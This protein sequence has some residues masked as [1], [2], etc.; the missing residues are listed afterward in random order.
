MQSRKLWAVAIIIISACIAIAVSYSQFSAEAISNWDSLYISD[1]D[2]T[3]LSSSKYLQDAPLTTDIYFNDEKLLYDS[4]DNTFYYSLIDDDE[5]AYSPV[6]ELSDSS[7]TLTVY[8][9]SISPESIAEGVSIQLILMQGNIVSISNLICT[10]LPIMNVDIASDILEQGGYDD[11]YDILTDVPSSIYL[12]DNRSDFNGKSRSIICDSK[13][14]RRGQTNAVHPSKS[15]R[16]SLLEDKNNLNGNNVKE[17]LLGLREDDDWILYSPYRDYEKIRNVFSMNLWYDSFCKENEWS[18]E[19]GTEYRYIELFINHHY[20]GLYALCYPID[21]KQVSLKNGETL[22]KKNDWTHSERNIELDYQE[23]ADGSGGEYILGG[24]SIKGEAGDVEANRYND[25]LSLYVNMTYST[26]PNVVRMTSDVTNAIDLWLYY[27][28]TQAVDNVANG[29][30]KNMYVT[31]KNSDSGIEGHKLLITPWDMDQTWRHVG[32]GVTSQY[33]DPG[34][35]MPIEWGTVSSLLLLGD[36]N[37]IADIKAR[38]TYL[39]HGAWSNEA[40]LAALDGYEQDIYGSG[41]FKRTQNR[42]PAGLYNDSS[43][44]LSEFKD[45][46]IKRLECMDDYVNSL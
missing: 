24:Y 18:V 14:R 34:Y 16:L 5:N 43:L 8:G 9:S 46:V 12:Y 23:Y 28:L 25:L 40:I 38:Y 20:H 35:D 29:G 32:D 2:Y 31:V 30:A 1:K 10:T 4:I 37:I 44:G 36:S 17:N 39:R 3:A 11:T 45:Y 13:I 7:I 19:N 15:Y 27:K 21:S 33:S 42:W 22:F 26:D 6:V 41:A